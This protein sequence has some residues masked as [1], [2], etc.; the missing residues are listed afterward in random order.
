MGVDAVSTPKKRGSK[1]RENEEKRKVIG[2]K[3]VGLLSAVFPGL[4]LLW[5]RTNPATVIAV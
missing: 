5:C 1:E 4:M 3:P 2:Q